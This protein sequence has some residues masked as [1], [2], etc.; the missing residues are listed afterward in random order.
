VKPPIEKVDPE[1]RRVH[2]IDGSS[3]DS[4]DHIFFATG[5]DFSFPFLLGTRI[6]DRRIE[7]LY[8][9]VFNVEDP[10]L[11]FVGMVSIYRMTALALVS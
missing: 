11:G 4:V 10:T 5:Y 3:E 1:T 8:Q 2:F 7:G 9:H 6:Q